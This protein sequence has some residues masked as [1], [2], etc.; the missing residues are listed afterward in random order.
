[1]PNM[2]DIRYHIK[3]VKQTRQIT[4]AMHMVS[5]ARMR[6]ALDGI[7]KNRAYFFHALDIIVDIRTHTGDISHRYLTHRSGD[8]V[9]YVV[10]SGEKGLSGSYNHAVLSL[11]DSLMT[12]KNVVEVY[13]IGSVGTSH[14]LRKGISPDRHF[15]RLAEKPKLDQVR[16]LMTILIDQ[17]DRGEIDELRIVY[18]RFINTL[19]REPMEQKLLPVELNDFKRGRPANL[20]D[21]AYDRA[22]ILYD[23]SPAQVLDALIPQLLIGYVYGAIV[24]AYASENCARMAAME[25]ATRSADKMI[26][27]LTQQYHSVRQLT[28]T[29][30][31]ADIIGA[32]NAANA[33]RSADAAYYPE[34]HNS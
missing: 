23:P 29:N 1:M 19:S 31:L 11:A 21:E 17:Y 32:A 28:I 26:D 22:L 25:N 18:T 30:E 9:A 8:K 4:N 24:H 14:F 16:R 5:A 33:A 7:A 10:V 27:K 6:R 3:S 34:G 2:S 13:T 20:E 15:E 12:D